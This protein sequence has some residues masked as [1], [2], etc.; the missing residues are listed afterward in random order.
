M[1]LPAAYLKAVLQRFDMNGNGG[2]EREEFD[3]AIVEIIRREK[4]EEVHL[5]QKELDSLWEK[6]DRDN[7]NRVSLSELSQFVEKL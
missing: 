6:A 2:L 1:R 4:N 7:N 3:Q 5:T